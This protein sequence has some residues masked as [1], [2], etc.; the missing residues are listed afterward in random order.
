[1]T[2][3]YLIGEMSSPRRYYLGKEQGFMQNKPN[4]LNRPMNTSQ[5]M[6]N[7]YD[8]FRLLA[9]RKNKPNSNPISKIPK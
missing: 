2:T 1:M 4:F 8:N 6:T 3:E 9:R 5:V 7:H